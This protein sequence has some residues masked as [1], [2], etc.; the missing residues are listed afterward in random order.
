MGQATLVVIVLGVIGGG[1]L[2]G[3]QA[4]G[5]AHERRFAQTA[6][7]KTDCSPPVG[8]FAKAPSPGGPTLNLTCLSP[9]CTALWVGLATAEIGPDD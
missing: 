3:V 8:H 4:K 6:R 2:L 9:P 1:A 7:W 5:K